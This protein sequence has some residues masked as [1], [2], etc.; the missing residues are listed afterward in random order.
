MSGV[1][2]VFRKEME[3]HFSS[4]RFVLMAALIIMVGIIIT[5]VVGMGIRDEVE[6]QQRSSLLFLYLFTSTGKMFSFSQFIAF[7]GP[8][9]GI[10]VGF[11]A[12]SKEKGWRTLNK[13]VSQPI[14]RDSI[15]NGKFLAG[16]VTLAIVLGSIMLIIAGLGIKLLGVVPGM[17]EIY[18]LIIYY[19]IALL[20]ISFWLGI[21]ILF[22]T[23][24][25]STSTSALAG[26]AAW[27]LSSFLVGLAASVIAGVIAPVYQTPYGVDPVSYNKHERIMRSISY[28]SPSSLYGYASATILDPMRKTSN[29]AVL[30]GPMERR[31]LSRYEN[32]LPVQQSFLIVL[33]YVVFLI[34][35][36]VICF[37]MSYI[38]FMRQEMRSV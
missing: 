24:F 33:P 3:D 21:A 15:I 5:S 26:V 31:S 14:Y 9:L 36:T 28:A 22:S 35:I 10:I 23:V 1:Y 6:G 12:I 8:L 4:S 18:R 30:M 17:D 20:Y 16:L 11:D 19:I 34:A 38:A 2:V 29:S 37:A 7:F 25:K 13:L 27:I 32:P